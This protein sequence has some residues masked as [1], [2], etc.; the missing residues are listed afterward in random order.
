MKELFEIC[1]KIHFLFK[2]FLALFEIW[3][4]KCQIERSDVSGTI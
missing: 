1:P 3:S 4:E 2:T